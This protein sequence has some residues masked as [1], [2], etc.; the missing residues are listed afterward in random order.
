MKLITTL[1]IF[2]EPSPPREGEILGYKEHGHDLPSG[3]WSLY[4]GEGD[5]TPAR[6]AIVRWKRK[7]K[8]VA[9]DMRNIL[10][11]EDVK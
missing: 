2:G 5:S 6:F 4:P 9:V 3:A 10:K 7:R 11:I 1:D 8:R